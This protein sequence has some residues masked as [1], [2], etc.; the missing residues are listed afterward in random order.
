MGSKD[1]NTWVSD[2]LMVLLGYSETAVVKYLIAKAKKSESPDEI[3]SEL[4]DYGFFLSG[5][6]RAFAEEIYA[7]VPRKTAGVNLYQQQEA[8]AAQLLKKQ[9]TFS[10]LEA[11]HDEDEG[12]AENQSA[13]ETGKSNKGQKRFRKKIEDS[14]DYDDDEVVIIREDKRNVR[15]KVSEGED[16][17]T[18]SEEERL[19]D[20]REREELEQH[21]RERDTA[22]TRKLTEP[23][24]SKKE[25]EE[26]ARRDSA[27]EKGDTQPIRNFSRQ[28]YLKK[29]ELR[30]LEE[31]K[32]Y[33]EDES[34]LF[35]DEKLTE[36][37]IQDFR[38]KKAIYELIK[39]RTQEEDNVGEYRMPDAYDQDGSVDQEKRF[40]VSV[41]RYRD[42]GSTEKMNPFAEQEAWEDHQIGNAT[43]KFGA[44]NKQ[45]SDNYEFVFEDQIDFIKAS[46]LAGD[47]YEDAMP[48]KPSQESTGK[49]AFDML[50]EE[51]KNLPIYSYR[52]QLLNAVKDHQV[53]IIVGETGS[54]KTTQI[55]Q[56]LHEA[57]Y[58]KHGKVGCTQ[59]Q[60]V[61]AMSVSARVAQ[62]MGVKLGHEVGYSIRFEDCTSEKTILKYMTD[63]M[64]LRELLGEPDLG[65][66]SVIIVDEA[67]ERTLHTDILFGLVKDIARARPDMKLLISSATM[68]AEKFSDFFDQAPIFSFPGRRY[69]VDICFT[70]APEADYM[71]AA[72]ATVLTIH[73]KEPLGDVLVFLPGQEEIEAVEENLKNKIRGLGTKIR[74]LIICPIYA[75]LPSELQAKIFEPTPE[76]ARKVV[77]AT[78]IAETSLT[79]DGIKYVVDPGFS[80]MKSYNPRT[81]MES[82]LVTPISKASATQR[83]GRAGRTSA[84]KCYRLYT[85]YNYYHDLEDNTIPEIQRTN[86]AS[87]V[88]SLKSLGIH[89]LLNFDFMDPPPSEALIKSLELLFALGA[90]NQLGELTKAGRRMAE[91]PLDPM[92]SKMIVVSDKYKCSDE[93]ISIAAMLSIGPSIFYRPKDKQ[94]H[95]YNAMMNFHVGNV[96]DHIALLKIYNSWKETNYSTQWCYENYI[97][98]RSMKRARDIRD[99]LEGLLERVE[100]EV[101][102][103]SNELDSIRKSIVAGFFPHTAKLQKNGSYRTVKHPQTVH[104]H[105]ASGLSQ[106]LPRWVVYHQLVL[107]S[108]EYMRQVTELKPE[109]LIEIAPHYYQLKD[110]EDAASKK[111]PK[112]SGPAVV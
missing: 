63:G 95:A 35:G 79:I 49:S 50:R 105:P 29:R 70:T 106:V 9:K 36:A 31:L 90:L 108:K 82:L 24:M 64:L 23:K 69:P 72:I 22:R 34:Y 68:D 107:T 8:E 45:V 40:A 6:T 3:V 59:P 110:V 38:Y 39:K 13:L 54:G 103:N 26:V 43:L 46:V 86:L 80:K 52:E 47:N 111:M 51:R 61:A 14:E 112:T 87:V 96:G 20:Q 60:R 109:W 41:Q 101:S 73:V 33:L 78:N 10:L 89:N 92:L 88:L 18:E 102:S 44:K 48:A 5:D 28:E 84:G 100:I 66:Y 16:D 32:D 74:E 104:I 55:P 30:K 83:A 15:R 62:E 71:D 27:V 57:G 56:Y 12:N 77:L 1:L 7:R 67:H 76:G 58:T 99:Q 93:I 2:K 91:F 65:S 4:L 37:E 19:R 81:G 94:V 25:Q 98:V 42:T 75:N 53:L 21:L 17:G 97:Q 85:A 11:D